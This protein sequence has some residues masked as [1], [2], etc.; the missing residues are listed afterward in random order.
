[1]AVKAREDQGF[2]WRTSSYS[3][4]AGGNCVEVGW[5][6][7]S[8]STDAGGNCVEAGLVIGSAQ[9][10]VR[11]TKNRARGHFAVSR[12]SWATFVRSVTR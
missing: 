3:T 10:A 9:V 4:Q 8:Y 2:A 1:M 5:R 6:K 12:T 11:D 7:S